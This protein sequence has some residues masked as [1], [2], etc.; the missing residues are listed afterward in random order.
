MLLKEKERER[1]ERSM[2]P[3]I[4]RGRGREATAVAKVPLGIRRCRRRHCAN[5]PFHYNFKSIFSLFL[6]LLLLLVVA[7]LFNFI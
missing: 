4:K 5:E 1:G 7:F 3:V 6:L 2:H